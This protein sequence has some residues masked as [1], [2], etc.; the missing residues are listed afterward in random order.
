MRLT[1]L[2]SALLLL[3]ANG[4]AGP[5]SAAPPAATSPSPTADTSDA[6]LQTLRRVTWQ[7]QEFTTPDGQTIDVRPADATLRISG[8]E[9]RAEA[10][11]SQRA[12]VEIQ[13]DAL[14]LVEMSTTERGCDPFSP[15]GQADEGL[16]SVQDAWMS[17]RVEDDR[18]TLTLAGARADVT[19]RYA[20]ADTPNPIA[21]G[22]EVASGEANG[23]RYRVSLARGGDRLGLVLEASLVWEGATAR[24]SSFRHIDVGAA[25]EPLQSLASAELSRGSEYPDP[26]RRAY[27]ATFVPIGAVRVVHRAGSSVE[28]LEL[29]LV[30]I[31]NA[32]FLVAA[33]FTQWQSQSSKLTAYDAAGDVVASWP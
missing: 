18:L 22:R 17:W 13:D 29:E 11:N 7:L 15:E 23:A 4:C 24:P 1:V 25:G 27:V 28:P 32:E 8:S 26:L 9:L 14:R 12:T 10:C 31:G 33:G 16:F 19:L 20:E 30:D 3:A 21:A 6:D 5:G 2:S